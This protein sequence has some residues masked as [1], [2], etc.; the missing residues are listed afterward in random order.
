MSSCTPSEVIAFSKETANILM[1]FHD[2]TEPGAPEFATGK[3]IKEE[4]EK[5][6][7]CIIS[8]AERKNMKIEDRKFQNSHQPCVSQQ[9][10]EQSMEISPFMTKVRAIEISGLNAIIH[11]SPVKSGKFWSSDYGCNLIQSDM[12]GNI[13]Q[14]IS[15]QKDGTGYHAI[16]KGGDLL[17]TDDIKRAIYMCKLNSEMKI[18]ALVTTGTGSHIPSGPL[19]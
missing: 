19:I 6:F 3:I 16:T 17:Y 14:K 15:T 1:K 8:C 9:L 11:L 18:T 13:L 4:I 10:Q 7:G 2:L 5:L 12:L